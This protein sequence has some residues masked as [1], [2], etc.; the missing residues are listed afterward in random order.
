MSIVL[1]M[2][3][4]RRLQKLE[5]STRKGSKKQPSGL[6]FGELIETERLKLRDGIIVNLD[7]QKAYGE[8]DTE[9]NFVVTCLTRELAVSGE[10]PAQRS[11][12]LNNLLVKMYNNEI[13]AQWGQILKKRVK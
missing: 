11:R 4:E 9:L 1:G 2:W 3:G 13:T 6:T 7:T 5:V 12:A 10:K 8:M